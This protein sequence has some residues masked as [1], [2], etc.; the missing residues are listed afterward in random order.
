MNRNVLLVEHRAKG[1]ARKNLALARYSTLYKS[2]GDNVL[3]VVIDSKF[4]YPQG[5][6]PDLVYISIIF[7]WDIP[8]IKRFVD[9]LRFIFP[10]LNKPGSIIL[11]GVCTGYLKEYIQQNIGIEPVVGCD[12]NLDHVV[13]DFSFFKDTDESFLFSGRGCTNKCLPHCVVP[14]IEPE[15]YEISNWREQ[16]DYSKKIT[17]FMDNNILCQPHKNELFKFLESFAPVSNNFVEGSRKIREVRF[18]SGFDWRLLNEENCYLISRIRHNQI[19]LAFDNVKFE[20]GFDEGIT[21]LLKFFPKVSSRELHENFS[22]YVLYNNDKVDTIE[23]ALYRAYKLLYHYRVRPFLMRYIPCDSLYY[24]K[25]VSP[26]W[27]KEDAIDI[28]RFF[29][30]RSVIFKVPR[31]LYYVGR[32]QDEKCI[33]QFSSLKG[34][35]NFLSNMSLPDIDYTKSFSYN[36][37]KIKG[38]LDMRNEAMA[39]VREKLRQYYQ[40]QIFEL[41]T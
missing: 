7:S 36:L 2:K 35:E 3:H 4:K 27:Q 41:I 20:A 12:Y 5:F 14:K 24:K 32:D 15:I 28:G 19:R 26:Q 8:Y 31:Y 22:C 29:N 18:D 10:H 17:V 9:E 30:H 33:N 11:G 25:Y 16:I 13:P 39:T 23:D 40:P 37:K 38:E 6:K 34:I 21:R 1:K